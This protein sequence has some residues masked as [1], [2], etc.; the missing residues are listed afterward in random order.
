MLRVVLKEKTGYSTIGIGDSDKVSKTVT[1]FNEMLTHAL[2]MSDGMEDD[3]EA[4][5]LNLPPMAFEINSQNVVV[6]VSSVAEQ[7]D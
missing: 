5:L 1:M 4:R 6:W 2:A 7:E 3:V